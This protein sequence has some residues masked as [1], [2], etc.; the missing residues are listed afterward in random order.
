MIFY[1]KK[2]LTLTIGSAGTRGGQGKLT[3]FM[4][5][6]WPLLRQDRDFSVF[7]LFTRARKLSLIY[8]LFTIL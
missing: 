4:Y 6:S 1:V 2:S 7:I 5:F 3:N 8:A